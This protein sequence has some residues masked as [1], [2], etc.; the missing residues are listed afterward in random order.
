LVSRK[1]SGR[2]VE[3]GREL[4]GWSGES[5]IVWREVRMMVMGEMSGWRFEKQRND[6]RE[7]SWG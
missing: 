2:I 4:K 6:M 7:G 3:A 1:T 5:K